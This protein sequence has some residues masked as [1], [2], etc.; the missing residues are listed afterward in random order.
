MTL[1]LHGGLKMQ[2][3]SLVLAGAMALI[4]LSGAR[5]KDA[6]VADDP[7]GTASAVNVCDAY[8]TGYTQVAGTGT[9]VKVSGEIRYQK[10]IGSRNSSG[11][12]GRM[13]LDFETRSD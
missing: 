7:L 3:N 4:A 2:I 10:T 13:T 1:S 5:A 9:C 8:G 11:S 12:N 6:V